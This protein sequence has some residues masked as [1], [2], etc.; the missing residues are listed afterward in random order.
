M[1][2][3]IRL[4]VKR[5]LYIEWVICIHQTLDIQGRSVIT[6]VYIHWSLH[7]HWRLHSLKP[8]HPVKTRSSED[9][10][11]RRLYVQQ[12]PDK[13]IYSARCAYPMKTVHPVKTDILQKNPV[14]SVQIFQSGKTMFSKVCT[15]SVDFPCRQDWTSCE[16]CV[17]YKECVSC[18]ESIS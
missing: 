15:S 8:A 3:L 18:K 17:F 4:Y 11:Q 6:W 7:V 9:Y 5:A 16:E 10:I 12:R 2:I 13:S 1:Y 14:N